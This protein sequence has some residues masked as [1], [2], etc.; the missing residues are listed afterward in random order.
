MTSTHCALVA[1]LVVVPAGLTAQERGGLDPASLR[2]PLSASWPTYSGDYSGRRYSALT[3]VTIDTVEHLS[4]AW[5][6]EL[7]TGMPALGGRAAP[8]VHR[9]RGDR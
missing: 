4:L 9:R 3:Q 6:R 1:A 5:T 7:N 8:T 2:E